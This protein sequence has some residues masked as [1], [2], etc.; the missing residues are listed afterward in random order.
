MGFGFFQPRLTMLAAHRSKLLFHCSITVL[1]F[2][3][4]NEQFQIHSKIKR[5]LQTVLMY[6]LPLH[7]HS[8]SHHRHPHNSSTFVTI[9]E[10]M[11]IQ[12]IIIQSLQFTV[13][14]TP[15]I[16]HCRHLDKCI[17]TH[18]YHYT[19]TDSIFTAL[20]IL[21]SSYLTFKL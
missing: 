6:P 21:C 11:M 19:I 17:M 7:M 9:D 2:F 12:D 1:K 14:F 8:H 4:S 15:G 10:N 20:N 18:F 16:I 13:E 3:F 5:K